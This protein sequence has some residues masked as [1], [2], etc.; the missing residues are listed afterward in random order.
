M[1]SSLLNPGYYDEHEL[2][3]AGFRALG[4]NVR[5]AKNCVM[6]GIG[7]IEI[8][9]NVRIDGFCSVVVPEGGWL[10]IGRYIHI[11]SYCLL[12]AGDGI[13]LGDFSGLSQGAKIYSRS[14]DYSGDHLTNPTIPKKF[15]GVTGGEVTLGRHVIVGSGSVI[16]PKVA[17][18]EG[19][20]VGALSLVSKSLDPWGVYA[21]RPVRKIKSRSQRLLELE[22]QMLQEEFGSPENSDA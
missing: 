18:G 13:V 4:K 6:V 15:T 11:G 19:S 22:A 2:K 16:L 21:G 5:I 17:I 8:G 7:N 3:N 9:D 10:R 1:I 20:S 14:D 12:S